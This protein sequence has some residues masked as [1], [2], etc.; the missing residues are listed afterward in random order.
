[1][2]A[3]PGPAKSPAD[4]RRERYINGLA[5]A[6]AAGDF[7]WDTATDKER[8]GARA[9]LNRAGIRI[10][11]RRRIIVPPPEAPEVIAKRRVDERIKAEQVLFARSVAIA[12]AVWRLRSEK[13][14]AYGRKLVENETVPAWF[15]NE[16]LRETGASADIRLDNIPGWEMAF[17]DTRKDFIDELTREA[18]L[19]EEE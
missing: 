19:A 11:K 5:M 8:R 3:K 12:R 6:A 10:P 4:P 14:P 2:T 1:M 16:I 15:A 13:D 18:G 9:I 7:R 17:T